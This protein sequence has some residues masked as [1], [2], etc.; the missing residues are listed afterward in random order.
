M[1]NFID[2]SN[3]QEG[4]ELKNVAYAIDAVCVKATEGLWFVDWTCDKFVQQAQKL[5]LPFAFYHFATNEDPIAEANYFMANTHNYFGKGIPVLDW[6]GV[7]NVDWVNEFVEHVHEVSGV[8]PWIYGN[9]WRF[10]EGVNQN[11][12]RWLASYPD[13]ES[14]TFMQAKAIKWPEAPGLV[15]A[16]QF[17]SDGRIEGYK[18]NLDCSLF[19]GDAEAWALYASGGR[20]ADEPKER[21]VYECEHVKIIEKEG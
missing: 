2:I 7:Q 16:W 13:I 9:P 21:T 3:Y 15:G 4:L 5:G 6:E 20:I 8:W 10:T 19:A 14:P 17:C 18:H 12:M 1:F 11:C